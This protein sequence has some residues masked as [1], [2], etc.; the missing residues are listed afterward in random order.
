[1]SAKLGLPFAVIKMIVAF[2]S[3]SAL[4]N[5]IEACGAGFPRKIKLI[6]NKSVFAQHGF[7]VENFCIRAMLI[8]KDVKY[9]FHLQ[10]AWK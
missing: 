5:F 10:V 8:K 7:S 9:V 6:V 3:A 2:S 1:M 4:V